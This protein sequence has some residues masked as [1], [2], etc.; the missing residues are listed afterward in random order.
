MSELATARMSLGSVSAQRGARE[1]EV[2]VFRD[3]QDQLFTQDGVSAGLV[4]AG[5]PRMVLREAEAVRAV[6][7]APARW[8][9]L[10]DL[11]SPVSS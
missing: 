1:R 7:P 5:E 10:R 8:V 3:V 2:A 6:T 9:P 4:R 11:V